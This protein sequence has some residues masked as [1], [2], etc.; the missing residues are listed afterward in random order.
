MGVW[1][2]VFLRLMPKQINPFAGKK[3][4]G[5]SNSKKAPKRG[6]G[7][8]KGMHFPHDHLCHANRTDLSGMV[9]PNQLGLQ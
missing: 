9:S 2:S 5:S 4:L 6:K 8:G 1:H 7:K 3:L